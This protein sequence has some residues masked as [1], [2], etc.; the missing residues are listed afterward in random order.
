[1]T[2]PGT[3][4]IGGPA[5]EALP[6][7]GPLG[8]G[9]FGNREGMDFGRVPTIPGGAATRRGPDDNLEFGSNGTER[10]SSR[11]QGRTPRRL[12][13]V[14]KGEGRNPIHETIKRLSAG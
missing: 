5:C 2:S 11:S 1:M 3:A 14:S 7:R 10:S 4:A 12:C 9:T 13:F 6:P 8:A